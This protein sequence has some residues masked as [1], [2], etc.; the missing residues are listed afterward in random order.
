M[1]NHQDLLNNEWDHY[2]KHGRSYIAKRAKDN[3]SSNSTVAKPWKHGGRYVE[4]NLGYVSVCIM[5]S[6][7]ECKSLT[8]DQLSVHDSPALAATSSGWL[9]FHVVKLWP[10]YKIDRQVLNIEVFAR[11][12]SFQVEG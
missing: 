12:C 1:E 8:D 7:T 5:P 11:S 2:W 10:L 6:A 4:G 9:G 3:L